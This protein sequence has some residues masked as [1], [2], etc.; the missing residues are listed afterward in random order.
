MKVLLL[1][2]SPHEA[3]CT[4]TALKEVADRLEQNGI[5]TEIF[6]LGKGPVQGCTDCEGCKTL[7]RCV[8]D[9]LV[10]QLG[11][12]LAAA[13]GFI[14]GSPVYFAS[15]NGTLVAALDRLFYVGRDKYAHKP[16]AA[17]VSARRGGTTAAFEV[18]NKYFA[19][20]RM[21]IVTSQYWNMVHGDTPEDVRQDLE[22]LQTMRTLADEMTWM[23]RC[24]EAGQ[25]AGITPPA[26][27]AKVRTN[28][29]R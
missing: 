18:I 17:V 2:G 1:N 23:L 3:G 6:Q 7:G 5:G 29:I 14:V 13:D 8:Y 9:D 16:A 10:T 11:E 25:K 15:A 4:Y 27:E 20:N 26:P 19:I 24:I 12:K 28:F 22:G 21:P